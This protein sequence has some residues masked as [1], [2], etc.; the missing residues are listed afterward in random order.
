[1]IEIGN[2]Q[3]MIIQMWV[4]LLPFDETMHFL[5]LKLKTSIALQFPHIYGDKGEKFMT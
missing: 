3:L 2:V 4:C 5:K 1:M